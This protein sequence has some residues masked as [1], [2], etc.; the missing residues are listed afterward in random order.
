MD[1]YINIWLLCWNLARREGYASCFVIYLQRAIGI[2][3]AL[4]WPIEFVYQSADAKQ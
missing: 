3:L 4:D 2:G 1:E